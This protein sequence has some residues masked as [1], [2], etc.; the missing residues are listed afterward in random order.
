MHMHNRYNY[1]VIPLLLVWEL[2]WDIVI[3]IHLAQN[4]NI[5]VKLNDIVTH[6]ELSWPTVKGMGS[7]VVGKT[8]PRVQTVDSIGFTAY[9]LTRAR[10]KNIK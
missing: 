9:I 6:Y 1:Y 5:K 3:S 10:N 2:S 7:R 8:K 4:L